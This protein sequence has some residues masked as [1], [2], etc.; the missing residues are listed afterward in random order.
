MF[1]ALRPQA[2]LAAGVLG[3]L[4]LG[5]LRRPPAAALRALALASIGGAL[6]LGNSLRLGGDGLL[7]VDVYAVAWLFVITLGALPFAF[8]HDGS[9]DVLTALF[10]GST[11]GMS[12]LVAAANL[13]MLFIALEFM[14]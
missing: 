14:S 6:L 12:L 1:A 9:D 10:L 8:W 3:A 4:S 13:P 5:L 11:L 7:R 2:A